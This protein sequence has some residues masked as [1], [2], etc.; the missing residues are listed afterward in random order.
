MR[1]TAAAGESSSGAAPQPSSCANP[2]ASTEQ[3]YVGTGVGSGASK[4]YGSLA[5]SLLLACFVQVESMELA[6]Q[7]P[8][9][10]TAVGAGV[11]GVGFA[12][13]IAWYSMGAAL[14]TSTMQNIPIVVDS[15]AGGFEQCVGEVVHGSKT[16]VRCVA[17]GLSLL[18]CLIFLVLAHHILCCFRARLKT[19]R[20]PPK[21]TR[22]DRLLGGAPISRSR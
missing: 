22:P 15:V 11:T 13:L 10:G 18:V 5:A 1:L 16:V 4:M 20:K 19:G 6:A 21:V 3:R 7:I 17:V 9:A 12:G 8:T 2:T 14:F